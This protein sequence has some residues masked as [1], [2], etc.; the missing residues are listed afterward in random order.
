MQFKS[1]ARRGAAVAVLAGVVGG[2]RYARFGFLPLRCLR[3]AVGYSENI[4]APFR[5]TIGSL[6]NVVLVVR[7]IDDPL[8]HD[9]ECQR[10]IGARLDRNPFSA[11]KLCRFVVV[12]IDVNEL[13][14]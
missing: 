7:A 9:R 12:R 11:E 2:C 6:L 5:E 8:M 1:W 4:V 14:P 3:D 13:D 10:R